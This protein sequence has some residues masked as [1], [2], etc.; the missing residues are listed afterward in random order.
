MAKPLEARCDHCKQNRPLFLYE[1]DHNC[2][3]LPVACRWC[4]RDK[5]PLLCTR[6]WDTEKQLEDRTP[7]SL[8]EQSIGSFLTAVMTR[9]TQHD[10][11]CATDQATCDGIAK[12]TEESAS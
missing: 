8:E 6:C 12:A 10:E 11:Q 1:P 3:L 9:S 5:Q 4:D 2:H 7:A